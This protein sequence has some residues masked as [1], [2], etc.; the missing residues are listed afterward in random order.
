M[1]RSKGL[2]S[3]LLLTFLFVAILLP[4]VPI[5]LWS[6][7]FRWAYPYLLPQWSLNAWDYV[8]GQKMIMKALFNSLVVS[9]IVTVLTLFIGYTA[10]KALGTR[11]FKGKL[12]IEMLILLPAVVPVISAVMGM[13][14]IFTMINLTDTF[15]GVILAQTVFTVTLHGPGA[16]GRIQEL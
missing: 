13:R 15:L 12:A 9:S 8:F 10:A 6:F 4:I 16:C 5:V 14:S 2:S 1:S 3:S 11:K 7:S